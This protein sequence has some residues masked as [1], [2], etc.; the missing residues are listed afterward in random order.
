MANN[1]LVTSVTHSIA[2]VLV[3][4][5]KPYWVE[6]QL[7]DE[8]GDAV[9]HIPWK[10]E[11]HHPNEGRI[12][13][14]TYLGV[15]DAEGLIRID[16]PHGLEMRLFLEAD[17]LAKEMEKRSLRVGR[18]AEAD[19]TVRPDA[20]GKGYKWHY[21]TIGELCHELPSYV[22]REG[23]VR[24]Q[25]HFPPDRVNKG[26]VIRTNEIELRHVVEICPFRA[27]E[28]MLYHQDDY[29]VENSFN[30][31]LVAD[32]SYDEI[33]PVTDFFLSQ[34]QDLSKLPSRKIGSSFINA[35]VHDIPYSNRYFPPVGLDSSKVNNP[36]GDTQLFYT[37]NN[38]KVLIGWRGTA[39]YSD[40]ITDAT[41]RPVKSQTCDTKL[42]CVDLVSHGKVHLGFWDGFNIINELFK[43]K[44]TELADI[45]QGRMLFISGHSLGG[46]LALIHAVKLA[47]FNPLL[48]TY[49]MPR[50]FTRDAVERLSGIT[51]F[52]HV[53]DKD[54]VPAVPPE[55]NLDNLFYNLWGP[56]GT[57]FGGIWSTAEL[58]AWQLVEWGD[59]YWHHG[60]PVVFLTTT[61]NRVWQQCGIEYPYPRNCMT[62][63]KKLPIKVKLYLVPSLSEA[64]VQNAGKEQKIF[65]QGLTEE[66][67]KVFF[68]AGMNPDRGS[69][70]NVFDHFMTSYIPYVNNKLLELVG[71]KGLG[72]GKTF[73]EHAENVDKFKF[74]MEKE[75]NELSLA[76]VKRNKNFLILEGLLKS[77]LDSTC[78]DIIGGRSLERFAKYS[79]EGMEDV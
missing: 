63:R 72:K 50:I 62:I 39:G 9:A 77:N 38:N 56:F 59:C 34:C 12:K 65:N 32:L 61:Q 51:H 70:L 60:H 55:A 31:G 6:V 76:E 14:L 1:S 28:L 46:A 4:K 48:Y 44:I 29:S 49:G 26:L 5:Q 45:I 21:A 64:N 20:L 16:M 43:E 11:S 13:Q 23:E 27:W 78:S 24:P 47:D 75:L 41:F 79:E 33:D 58:A 40:G 52:R 53:N 67:I 18:D 17:P 69:A 57:I 66:D 37:Y 74:Q 2:D 7:V 15:S 22:L 35:L 68:P 25:F 71:E 36:E 10:A 19:S 8:L 54:P 30:L 3:G 73:T 42:N